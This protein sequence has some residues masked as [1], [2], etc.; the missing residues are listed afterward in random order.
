M[1]KEKASPPLEEEK[2]DAL[3]EAAAW[4]SLGRGTRCTPLLKSS[5]KVVTV[6]SA[7]AEAKPPAGRTR[8]AE[9]C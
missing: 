1:A 3:A 9:A 6:A 8:Q 4:H 7:V 5:M 2:A